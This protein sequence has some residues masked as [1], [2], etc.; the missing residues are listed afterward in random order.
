MNGFQ[1]ERFVLKVRIIAAGCTTERKLL[2]KVSYDCKVRRTSSRSLELYLD[3]TECDIAV[4]ESRLALRAYRNRSPPLP[5]PE[6]VFHIFGALAEFECNLI[7]E[8][9]MVTDSGQ[10]SW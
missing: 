5:H 3:Q 6:M 4:M 10:S 8:R 9:T 7:R 1:Y 2:A